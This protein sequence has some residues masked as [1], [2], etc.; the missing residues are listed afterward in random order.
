M[1]NGVLRVS[2]DVVR[3]A[4]FLDQIANMFRHTATSKGLRLVYDR[5]EVLPEFVRMDQ[6]RLRQVLINLLSNAMKFTS[7]GSVCFRITYAGQMAS[8]EVSD[9]GPGIAP[10][11]QERIFAPFERG[12]DSVTYDKPGVGLGLSIT[13]ALVQIMGGEVLLDS[14]VGRGTRFR[15][16]LMLGQVAGQVR[17]KAPTARIGGYE[18][19]QRS[20][21][22]VDD[23]VQ[24]L[25]LMRELLEGLG[26][27]VAVAPG[28]EAALAL[29]A[30]GTFDL[31]V[32]DIT[33][34][35]ISG[36]ETA[37]RLRQA[38]GPALRIIMLSANAHEK[39]GSA[40]G[41][42]IHDLF[43]VKP[44]EL[45]ALVEAIGEQLDLRWT[46]MPSMQ[47]GEEVT[48]RVEPIGV[49]E[50][51]RPHI[52]KIREL[53]HIGY[54]R[55]IEQEI[56]A[57]AATGPEAKALSTRLFDYLDR[58]DLTGMNAVLEPYS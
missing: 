32:L 54:V 57:L 18:G 19:R 21:L 13:R 52:E 7:E 30:A 55:G 34:P 29:S 25:T 53:L 24:H 37:E 2:N 42:P 5:P 27:D 58:F 33:M 3:F 43:L 12:A 48:G 20:I 31:A 4:P 38:H 11:D 40:V 22:V 23:D 35:G 16:R 10:E 36:W 1:E 56:K 41:S 47:D 28:G 46:R 39:T 6:K 8:F 51:A 14:E 15:V 49:D 17:E 45:G 26:F 44:V 50:A 9:T